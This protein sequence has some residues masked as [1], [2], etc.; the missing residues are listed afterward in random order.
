M[1]PK[2][3]TKWFKQSVLTNCLLLSNINSQTKSREIMAGVFGSQSFNRYRSELARVVAENKH[4]QLLEIDPEYRRAYEKFA[5]AMEKGDKQLA[6]RIYKKKMQ[7]IAGRYQ[8]DLKFKKSKGNRDKLIISCLPMVV[9]LAKSFV[10]RAKA[11]VAMD[12]LVQA[13]NLGLIIAADRYLST[14]IPEGKKEAKFS[15]VAYPWIYKYI[16]E[17]AYR[18]STSFGGESAYAAWAA[19]KNTQVLRARAEDKNEGGEFTNDVWDDATVNKLADFKEITI[20]SD[21]LK[22]VRAASKKLFAPLSKEARRI[23]FMAYGID[24]PNNI[25]YSVEEIAKMLGQSVYLV[26]KSITSSIQKL[27]YIVRGQVAGEDLIVALSQIHSVDLSQVP[28]WS[29]SDTF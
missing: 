27:S 3:L 8:Y 9:A 22:R 18:H 26:K 20:A 23:L 13:G 19:T 10:S 2:P 25:V 6:N 1:V 16:N 12:D 21:E 7:E 14:P 28:E 5:E 4:N 17:E 24:T 29:M 15:T 11:G